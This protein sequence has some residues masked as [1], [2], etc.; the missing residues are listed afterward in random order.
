M[1]RRRDS[2]VSQPAQLFIQVSERVLQQLPM[3][4]VRTRFHLLQHSPPRETETL[5]FPEASC[6]FPAHLRTTRARLL[7]HLCLLR[8]HRF[9]FPP[10]GH[11]PIIVLQRGRYSFC[12]AALEQL[13][14]V[15]ENSQPDRG[16][17]S[18]LHVV[19]LTYKNMQG[20]KKAGLYA[21][22][23]YLMP[24]IRDIGSPFEGEAV[25]GDLRCVP[26]KRSTLEIQ[27]AMPL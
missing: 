18:P 26:L 25:K 23:M 11:S 22:F 19:E 8:F 17:D 27:V 15:T 4:R 12:A 21:S 20:K 6:F 14:N 2:S 5:F 16:S 3:P 24:I 9:A 10:S 1:D 13:G 7:S